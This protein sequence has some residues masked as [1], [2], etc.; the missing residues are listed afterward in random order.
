MADLVPE[1]EREKHYDRWYQLSKL[2][3]D[4]I[5]HNAE[6]KEIATTKAIADDAWAAY[7]DIVTNNLTGRFDGYEHPLGPR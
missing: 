1:S 7:V 3:H 6:P 4:A 2:Y 5:R